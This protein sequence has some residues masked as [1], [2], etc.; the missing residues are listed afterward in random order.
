MVEAWR[1]PSYAVLAALY[2]SDLDDAR[3]RFYP[4]EVSLA[5][6]HG[7]VISCPLNWA[8]HSDL[9]CHYVL[10][11]LAQWP[12][13]LCPVVVASRLV[14]HGHVGGGQRQSALV[15][16]PE[17]LVVPHVQESESPWHSRAFHGR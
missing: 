16:Y 2:P 15:P 9:R 12:N 8:R 5:Y 14:A 6:H 17:D 11:K 1:C 7:E 10:V 13:D 4:K 3:D